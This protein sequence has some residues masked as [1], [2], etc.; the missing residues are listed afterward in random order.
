[1][2]TSAHRIFS[3][4]FLLVVALMPALPMRGETTT[5]E[6]PNKLKPSDV[7]AVP[8]KEGRKEPEEK[9]DELLQLDKVEVTGSRIPSLNG[10]ATALP[11]FTMTQVE[12]EQRGVNR[13][14]DIRWAIPQ[15]AASRGYNDNLTNSGTSRAQTVGT[16]INLRG[17]GNTTTLILIDGHRIPHTGQEA[18]GG[19]GGREDYNM[20]GIPVSAIDRIEVLTQGASAIYGADAITG[21]VNIILKKNFTGSEVRISYDNTFGKD[22]A[23]RT[24]EFTTGVTSGKWQ[25]FAS[26]SFEDDHGMRNLDRWFTATNDNTRFGGTTGLPYAP[27]KTGV[28]YVGAKTYNIP[29]ASNGGSAVSVADYT[30]AGFFA[31]G[32]GI[33]LAPYGTQLDPARKVSGTARIGYNLATW[34]E[35]Y[36]T[37]RW[38]R[39]TDYTTAS[40]ESVYVT[41][42]AGYAGNP[43]GSAVT[44][45]KYFTDLAPPK[46]T[47]YFENPSVTAGAKGK[48]LSDW[49]YDANYSWARNIVSDTY[50]YAPI[51]S[52][53][54][55]AAINN[56]DPAKRPIL[57][58]DSST[59]GANPNPAGTF[60]AFRLNGL[61]KDTSDTATASID[62]NGPVVTLPTG[63]IN[64]AAGA[65]TQ[66]DKV[67]FHREGSVIYSYLLSGSVRRVTDSYYAELQ[68]PLLSAAQKLPFVNLL[69]GGIA[70]RHDQIYDIKQ[71]ATTPTYT[72]IF[73]PFRWLT[74][75]A[76][77][78]EGFKVPRLYD[79]RAPVSNFTRTLTTTSRVF[80]SQ[81]NNEAVLGVLNYISGGNPYLKPENSVSKGLGFALDVPYVKGLS[82]AVDAYDITYL[83]QSGSTSLQTLI[84]SFPERITRGPALGDGLPGKIVSYDASNIN[85]AYTAIK[86]VDYSVRYNRAIRWGQLQASA[87]LT[88]PQ[89]TITQPTPASA[90]SAG[91]NP[92]R[93]SG[94]LF[95]TQGSWSAGTSVD[96]QG[97]APS[98][99]GSTVILES[100]IQWIPQVSYDFGRDSRFGKTAATVWGRWLADTK[101]SL[102]LPNVFK[103]EP[104][105]HEAA[106]YTWVGDPRLN[107]YVV[108]LTKKF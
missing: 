20:D 101:L 36:A 11:V 23:Q 17:L 31:P 14:A 28:L 39:T 10:E 67:T 38:N 2:F 68:V 107:R 73:R 55:N 86:G 89:S 32:Q 56:A 61:H 27:G 34:L 12:L 52:A 51:Y 102:T 81:R 35:F 50:T 70:Y 85:L 41:L 57:A 74:F 19:A 69:Q 33:D 90:R 60:D 99:A 106:T 64:V 88:V 78:S 4:A 66:L 21:V 7:A 46:Q 93:F 100:L 80:D 8:A 29:A 13:L 82:F 9:K 16:S 1:M 95:W 24:L 103:N 49:E 105:L 72:G 6:T 42:P 5:D 22:A 104:T 62:V 54:L 43:F 97:S 47:S 98:Y 65:E 44:L 58:Y 59:P 18:P 3:A 91:Q 15:L 94:Q 96:Y 26:G 87:T 108:S 48:F 83:N 79:L 71:S 45:Q 92:K 53:L 84:N 63:T 76:S 40:P 37:T 77:R 30:A 75:R 25:I